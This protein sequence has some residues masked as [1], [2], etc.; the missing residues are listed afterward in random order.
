MKGMNVQ[1]CTLCVCVLTLILVCVLV[2]RNV[3]EGFAVGKNEPDDPAKNST[4]YGQCKSHKD[5]L[6][7][8]KKKFNEILEEWERYRDHLIVLSDK[9]REIERLVIGGAGNR[10]QLIEIDER[11][12]KVTENMGIYYENLE[13][14]HKQIK[15]IHHKLRHYNCKDWDTVLPKLPSL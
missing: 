14:L 2:Y 5:A 6:R 3:N 15:H 8:K 1:K 12:E 4:G 11:I 13:K 9:R 7:N 10:R